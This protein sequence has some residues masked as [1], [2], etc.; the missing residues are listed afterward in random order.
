MWRTGA[1]PAAAAAEAS[2]LERDSKSEVRPGGQWLPVGIGAGG[3]TVVVV[4]VREHYDDAERVRNGEEWALRAFAETRGARPLQCLVLARRQAP[5]KRDLG[6]HREP[7]CGVQAFRTL[8]SL[9]ARI[10]RDVDALAPR[11]ER[12]RVLDDKG[13]RVGQ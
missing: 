4:V 9:I 1:C 3:V 7:L 8:V 11:E 2:E 6:L 13:D 12:V 10:Q 5:H